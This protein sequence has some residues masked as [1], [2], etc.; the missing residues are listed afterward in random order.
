VVVP[1]GRHPYSGR[2]LR[3]G[4]GHTGGADIAVWG[5]FRHGAD[6]GVRGEGDSAAAAFEQAALALTAVIVDPAL[7]TGKTAV[8][9]RCHAPDSAVVDATQ[10]AGL[11]AKVASLKPLIVIKG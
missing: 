6:I 5:H 4:V 2:I 8:K 7:V 9:I 11:A 3:R 1:A 10:R